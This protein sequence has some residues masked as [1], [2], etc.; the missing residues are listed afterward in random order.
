MFRLDAGSDAVIQVQRRADNICN[1]TEP[2]KQLNPSVNDKFSVALQKRF[3]C[4][5]DALL[6]AR[7]FNFLAHQANLPDGSNAINR[8]P[9]QQ[10]P[11]SVEHLRQETLQKCRSSVLRLPEGRKSTR[12]QPT[13]G[14]ASFEVLGVRRKGDG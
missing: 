6:R 5:N 9:L 13:I 1:V 12:A 3:C 8:R 4:V 7:T 10:H 2:L 14:K 11:L